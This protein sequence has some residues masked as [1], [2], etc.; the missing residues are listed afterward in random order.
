MNPIPWYVRRLDVEAQQCK[1]RGDVEG[2]W[3][4]RRAFLLEEARLREEEN[5]SQDAPEWEGQP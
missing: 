1:Q 3:R 5:A 4:N 2:F